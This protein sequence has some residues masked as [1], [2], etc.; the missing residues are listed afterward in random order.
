MHVALSPDDLRVIRGR[1]MA[2]VNNALSDFREHVR[3]VIKL[4][5][6]IQDG[7]RYSH[8][9]IAD[10]F[11]F[12]A[13]NIRAIEQKALAKLRNSTFFEEVCNIASGLGEQVTEAV[14]SAKM[15]TAMLS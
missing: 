8:A 7:R 10:I 11:G 3:D 15:D 6:G 12:T 4:R 2:F 1:L 14:E 13:Q 9:E 5:T